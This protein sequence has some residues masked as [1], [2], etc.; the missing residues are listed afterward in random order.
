MK[1][2]KIKEENLILLFIFW[3]ALVAPTKIW[4]SRL[5]LVLKPKDTA[6]LAFSLTPALEI[7]I[8]LTSV[9]TGN[10]ETVPVTM[11]MPLL[12]KPKNISKC[13]P[14][15]LKSYHKLFQIISRST[16]IMSLLLGSAWEDTVL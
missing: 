12:T 6:L 4:Q 13:S 1:R 15:S 2:S 9:K 3:G 8:F 10:L 11:L 16:E 7:L 5:G 14:T